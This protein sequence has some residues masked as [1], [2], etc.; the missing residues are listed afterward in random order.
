MIYIYIIYILKLCGM[1][2]FWTIVTK[3]TEL[4]EKKQVFS[5]PGA[6][7]PGT[8]FNIPRVEVQL[9]VIAGKAWEV[10]QGQHLLRLCCQVKDLGLG[11]NGSE[12]TGPKVVDWPIIFCWFFWGKCCFKHFKPWDLVFFYVQ[13]N[14]FSRNPIVIWFWKGLGSVGFP[15]KGCLTLKPRKHK[16][17]VE[18][19]LLPASERPKNRPGQWNGKGAGAIN[20]SWGNEHPQ[21][22]AILMWKPR[23][24]M[25]LADPSSCGIGWDTQFHLVFTTLHLDL[26][27]TVMGKVL[28]YQW[29]WVYAYAIFEL[30]H[31]VHKAKI[32]QIPPS[33]GWKSL[34]WQN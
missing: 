34:S 29:N 4:E 15:G 19:P 6:G 5:V 27:A 21:I 26:I 14:R 32:S 2:L 1:L 18:I 23:D 28:I 33:G 3:A 17:S 10:L 8:P 11:A 12:R 22:P 16:S 31:E 13:T 25:A 24:S 9:S 30:I 7:A 20:P